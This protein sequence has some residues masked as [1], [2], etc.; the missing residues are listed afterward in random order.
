MNIMEYAIEEDIRQK[1]LLSTTDVV[2]FGEVKVNFDGQI[3]KRKAIMLEKKNTQPL[4]Q[5]ISQPINSP[6]LLHAISDY[7]ELVRQT[8]AYDC[9]SRI[10]TDEGQV[11]LNRTSSDGLHTPQNQFIIRN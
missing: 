2:S 1:D 4:D 11:Q 8:L 10:K 9:D 7:Q 6:A 3:P 5:Q